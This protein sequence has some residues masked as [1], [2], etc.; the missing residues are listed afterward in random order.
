MR[1][2]Y[3]ALHYSASRGKNNNYYYDSPAV[4]HCCD[5]ISGVEMSNAAEILHPPPGIDIPQNFGVPKHQFFGSI[6][7]N[8]AT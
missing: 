2:P 3:R 1:S 6:F 4:N 7:D 8:F 5:N